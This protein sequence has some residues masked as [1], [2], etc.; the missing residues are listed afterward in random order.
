[1]LWTVPKIPVAHSRH[2]DSFFLLN[3]PPPSPYLLVFQLAG[4]WVLWVLPAQLILQP[5][6]GH[7]PW[8][9]PLRTRCRAL[10]H[11]EREEDGM[12]EAG[13]AVSRGGCSSWKLRAGSG[14]SF[15]W[16]P[17][18]LD[19]PSH[20]GNLPILWED[21]S[22]VG[23]MGVGFEIKPFPGEEWWFSC[24]GVTNPA[25]RSWEQAGSPE[26]TLGLLEK[27]WTSMWQTPTTSNLFL[28]IAACHLAREGR[29]E[30]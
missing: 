3:P 17:C 25:G 15:G 30:H 18:A 29:L 26:P 4:R 24:R 20:A 2:K 5:H 19:L 22:G 6:S 23:G 10:W 9:M 11:G 1:M 14:N 21:P 12:E 13:E 27:G 7:P 16:E 8:I 28:V